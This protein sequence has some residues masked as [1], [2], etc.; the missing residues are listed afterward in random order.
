MLQGAHGRLLLLQLQYVFRPDIALQLLAHIL[1]GNRDPS[2]FI[3][4]LLMD[5][6]ILRHRKITI[7]HSP[8]HLHDIGKEPGVIAYSHKETN[9]A[10]PA[11]IMRTRLVAIRALLFKSQIV[12]LLITEIYEKSYWLEGNTV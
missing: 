9:N 6:Q 3:F 8:Q 11:R 2:V 5:I 12:L 1:K 4:I 10:P 7:F